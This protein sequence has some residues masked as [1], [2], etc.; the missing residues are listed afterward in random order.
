ME[1]FF[2][3][4][5]F[6]MCHTTQSSQGRWKDVGHFMVNRFTRILP[7]YWLLTALALVVFLIAPDKVN[8]SGGDTKIWQSF[9]LVP[10]EGKFLI[11]NGWTLTYEFFFYLLFL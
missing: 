6:I 7:L 8:S 2:I 4:S 5:G 1:L 3:I 9:L 11:M 10:S